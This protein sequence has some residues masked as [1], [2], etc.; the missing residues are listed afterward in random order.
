[1][2]ALN[3]EFWSTEIKLLFYVYSNMG[4]ITE[5]VSPGGLEIKFF[6]ETLFCKAHNLC[7][8]HS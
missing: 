5:N 6:E 8:T 1:M 7:W 4:Y 3:M 2:F